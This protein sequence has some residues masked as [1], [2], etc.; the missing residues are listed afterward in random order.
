MEGR[1]EIDFLT[2][3]FQPLQDKRVLLASGRQFNGNNTLVAF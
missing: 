1:K 2:Q 3:T